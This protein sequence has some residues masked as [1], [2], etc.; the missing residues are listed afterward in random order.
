MIVKLFECTECKQCG[1]VF[2]DHEARHVCVVLEIMKL[3]E[4]TECKQCGAVFYDHEARHVCVVL[5]IMKLFECTE[6]TQCGAVFEIMKPY[7][8]S[9]PQYQAAYHT[10]CTSGIQPAVETT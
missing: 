4:C 5:E 2:Y 9:M 6:C 8:H 3:F 10:L 7:M 1:A